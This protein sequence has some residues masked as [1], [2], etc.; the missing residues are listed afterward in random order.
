M[1]VS[2]YSHQD[3]YQNNLIRNEA[4]SMLAVFRRR[5]IC[6]AAMNELMCV[7]EVKED[8]GCRLHPRRHKIC[9]R[10]FKK[11]INILTLSNLEVK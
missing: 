5:R 7:L 8:A 10:I 3:A 11:W 1:H 6:I 4:I 2:Q 9:I